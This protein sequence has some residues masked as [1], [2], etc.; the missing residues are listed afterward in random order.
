LNLKFL[1]VGLG[2]N[3]E[4]RHYAKFRGDRSNRCRDI[5][6]FG[7]F[8]MAAEAI[9]DFKNYKVLMVGTLKKVELHHIQISSKSLEPWPRYGDFSIFPRRRPSAILH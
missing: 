8:K 2:M 1:T 4:R 9:S 5:A 6:I 3:V 7:C